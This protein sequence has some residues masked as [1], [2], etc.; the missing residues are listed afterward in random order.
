MDQGKQKMWESLRSDA[1]HQDADV[2]DKLTK[3]EVLARAKV[4][5]DAVK[6][7]FDETAEA[8]GEQIKQM[9]SVVHSMTDVAES[10]QHTAESAAIVKHSQRFQDIIADKQNHLQRIKNDL[11]RRREKEELIHKV[12][13]EITV[14]NESSE[15]RSLTKENESLRHTHR[16]TKELLDEAER[17]RQRLDAQR[18]MFLGISDKVVTV[19]EKVPI[20]GGILKRIDQKRRRNIVVLAIVVAFC[21]FLT[22]FFW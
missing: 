18:N 3:L 15:M 13:S 9:Q 7:A 1:R 5:D 11:K 4:L 6:S 21:L 12:H 2:E 16:K 20:I 8:A 22:Y 19:A 10:M 14:Y 17:D